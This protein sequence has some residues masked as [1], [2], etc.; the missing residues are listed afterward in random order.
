MH[1]NNRSTHQ[2]MNRSR[3][4]V[5]FDHGKSTAATRLSR[6]FVG[7]RICVCCDS[8]ALS[9]SERNS[10]FISATGIAGRTPCIAHI[11]SNAGYLLRMALDSFLDVAARRAQFSNPARHWPID[12]DRDWLHYD[13]CSGDLRPTTA[14]AAKTPMCGICSFRRAPATRRFKHDRES[15]G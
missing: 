11:Q 5:V 12:L 10:G 3:G 9:P 14:S 1:P 6:T 8:I 15:L 13:C 7:L 2:A 4:V